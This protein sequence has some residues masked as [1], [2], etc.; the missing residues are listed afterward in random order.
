MAQ[1]Q[2]VE[3]NNIVVDL[4][5]ACNTT[6]WSTSDNIARHDSCN[7]GS[8][9]LNTYPLTV[10]ETYKV[11]YVVL[12]ISGGNVQLF[13][14][15]QA[16]VARTTPGIYV[17]TIVAAGANPKFS[18]FSNA[19]CTLQYFT[20]QHVVPLINNTIIF[21]LMTRKWSDFRSIAPDCGFSIFTDT[22][23]LFEGDL[24]SNDNGSDN[25]NSFYGVEYP[26][27]V[28]AQYAVAPSV[29]KTFLS[30]SLQ[31]NELMITTPDGITTSLGQISELVDADFLKGILSAPYLS[32]AQFSYEGVYAASFLRDKNVDLFSGDVL[33]GN[34]IIIELTTVNSGVLKLFTVNVVAEHSAIGSR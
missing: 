9:I 3:N 13:A 27:I 32:I 16:G 33:K 7:Q 15:T 6:G 10:G 8:I 22:I 12:T 21:Q 17:E 26:S 28:K 1:Y 19:N 2:A 11:S 31:V 24:W 23:T 18:F 29:P 30:L 5:V 34:Y 25:R 4:L 20:P 14:G